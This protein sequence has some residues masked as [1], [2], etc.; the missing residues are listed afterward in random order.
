MFAC[1]RQAGREVH[2]FQRPGKGSVGK[3]YARF[4]R[5][6]GGAYNRPKTPTY[7]F[8]SLALVEPGQDAALKSHWL[9]P[10]HA[11]LTDQW[12]KQVTKEERACVSDLAWYAVW[13]H[14]LAF[15]RTQDS[16]KKQVRRGQVK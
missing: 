6:W 12:Q 1:A 14:G 11:N 16:L 8:G 3:L 2:L 10:G 13:T 7:C 5:A 15:L 4:W 9:S